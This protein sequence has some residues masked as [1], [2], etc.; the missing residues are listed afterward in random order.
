M[1]CDK[2]VC[3]EGIDGQA[4]FRQ[5]LTGDHPFTIEGKTCP[6]CQDRVCERCF[7]YK[8]ACKTCSKDLPDV[9]HAKM[10]LIVFDVDVLPV[11]TTEITASGMPMTILVRGKCIKGPHLKCCECG[12]RWPYNSGLLNKGKPCTC[13]SKADE[14]TGTYCNDWTY[15]RGDEFDN[16]FSDEERHL[17]IRSMSTCCRDDYFEQAGDFPCCEATDVVDGDIVIDIFQALG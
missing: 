9:W 7:T 17:V 11:L 3:R 13:E 6:T 15:D 8:G 4:L 10:G 12:K 1:C 2:H 14:A 5:F 16:M